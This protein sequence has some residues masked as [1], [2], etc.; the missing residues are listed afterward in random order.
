MLQPKKQKY[1]K[2]FRGKRKGIA[3]SGYQIAF[4][5]YGLKALE[6]GWLS[7]RQIESAR[8]AITH[9][10]KR[11]GKIWIRIF[12][13]KPVTQK[14]AGAKMGGGKGDIN[15]YVGVVVPGKI[16]FEL[17]GIPLE[18]AK[19]AMRLASHKLPFKTKFVCREKK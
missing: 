5:Q 10:T 16:I 13:D 7:A 2:Q 12:P 15:K 4:G 8:K 17:S 9:H 19:G 14:P 6:R 18:V 11:T 1:R 3:Q